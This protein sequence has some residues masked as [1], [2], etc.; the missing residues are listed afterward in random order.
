M[1]YP[2]Q[3]RSMDDY[4]TAWKKSVE[5]PAGFWSDV[6]KH[7]TWKKPWNRVL[8]WNFR[9]PSVKWFD[10]AQLNITEN[11]IDRHLADKAHQPAIIWEPNDPNE[12]Q[13]ILT[14]AQLHEEVCCFGRVLLNNGVK[15]GDRVCIYMGMIPELA[16]AV[17]ACARIGAIHSVIFGGF[18][19]QSIADRLLDANAEFIV[20]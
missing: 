9:D 10:G 15:K 7:F 17:L 3:I 11:C 12:Q 18:S 20:T 6:A 14:Y 19:A 13:R 16:I 2:Y 1:S 8:D 5:D 4:T